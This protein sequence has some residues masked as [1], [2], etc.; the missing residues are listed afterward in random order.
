MGSVTNVD[1]SGIRD[2]QIP[3]R[4]ENL[5]LTGDQ[6]VIN[7]GY[8]VRWNIRSPELYLFQL[9]N[10]DVTVREVAESA[11]RAQVA[12]VSLDDALGAGRGEIEIPGAAQHAA[13]SRR[14]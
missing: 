7:L 4:G 6:N 11:M 1:V 5:I 2:I 3:G 9:A 13:D 8:T 10:P 12:R 14:L